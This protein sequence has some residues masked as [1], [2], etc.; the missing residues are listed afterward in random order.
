VSIAYE[1]SKMTDKN[2]DEVKGRVKE[3]AGSLTGD[4]DLKNEGKVDQAKSSVKDT[5]DKVADKVTPDDD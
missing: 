5:V 4:K 3:A 1:R 2:V